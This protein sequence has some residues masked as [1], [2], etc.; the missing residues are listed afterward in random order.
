M[1]KSEVLL[2]QPVDKLGAEGDQVVVKAGYARNY[3]LPRKLAVPL[4][5]ANRK[6]M[7]ALKARRAAREA[8]ALEDAKALAEKI[9]ALRFA[10]AVKTGEGGKLFGS[11]TAMDLRD[12]LAEAGVELD[13]KSVLLPAPIKELGRHTAAIKLHPE[14]ETEFA[15]EVVSEN[16]IVEEAE[17]SEA[18]SEDDEA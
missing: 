14:V 8:K 18:D 13:R 2:V 12:K 17:D 6:Q 16:P 9:A 5:R 10:I 4:T 3:L 11:V 15:F 7:E 1:A